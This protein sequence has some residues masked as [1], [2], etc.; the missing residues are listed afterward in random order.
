MNCMWVNPSSLG[1]LS[2]GL[3]WSM[4]LQYPKGLVIHRS[5]RVPVGTI[6]QNL[7]I[8]KFWMIQ[9]L[10]LTSVIHFFCLFSNV[11][12]IENSISLVQ[13]FCYLFLATGWCAISIS[14]SFLM[15]QFNALLWGPRMAASEERQGIICLGSCYKG[16]SSWKMW[17]CTCLWTSDDYS[18]SC[19]GDIS[20][21][22]HIFLSWNIYILSHLY[23]LLHFSLPSGFQYANTCSKNMGPFR[24][25]SAM[26]SDYLSGSVDYKYFTLLQRC[27]FDW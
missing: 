24:N 20:V 25:A 7:L 6:P 17:C 26:D 12:K 1:S 15:F 4:C 14:L 13:L 8:G 9:R 27:V 11:D 18:K 23:L 10:F 2:D 22:Y 5:L 16:W 3:W 19:P 21:M